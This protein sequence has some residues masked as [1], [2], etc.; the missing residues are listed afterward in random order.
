MQGRSQAWVG[1][2]LKPPSKQKCSPPKRNE[3]HLPFWAW[4]FFWAFLILYLTSGKSAGRS[5]VF[6]SENFGSNFSQN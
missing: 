1:G 4:S 2:G 3:A 6:A 5:F